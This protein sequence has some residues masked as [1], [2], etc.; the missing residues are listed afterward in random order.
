MYARSCIMYIYWDCMLKVKSIWFRQRP[1][2]AKFW[3]FERGLSERLKSKKVLVLDSAKIKAP[4]RHSPYGNRVSAVSPPAVALFKK[5]GIWSSLVDLRVKRVDRLEVLDSCSR[6]SIR[7]V[8]KNSEDE[9]A[10]IVENNAIVGFL[11]ERIRSSC[12]NVAV[13]RG[14]RVSG[15]KIPSGLDDYATVSLDDGTTLRTSLIIGADGARSLVR[16]TLNFT[17]TT[18]EYGQ[19]AVVANLRVQAVS[20]SR[21]TQFQRHLLDLGSA[22]TIHDSRRI[23]ST[24]GG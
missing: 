19:K 14:A 2:T 16:N 1:G 22:S 18:W 4:E 3:P 20:L 23:F 11:T 24:G 5:L 6:S 9:I 10:Y 15:C 7:F 12:P 13:R 21:V 8:Q 17:Y